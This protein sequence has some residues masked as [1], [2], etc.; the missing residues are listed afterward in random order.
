LVS[1]APGLQ[2]ENAP[3]V[4][5][6]GLG[7]VNPGRRAIG[8][9]QGRGIHCI[10]TTSSKAVKYLADAASADQAKSDQ[11]DSMGSP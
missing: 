5:S 4:P 2:I 9:H 11:D 3:D 10:V 7:Y 8:F 1:T 6:H